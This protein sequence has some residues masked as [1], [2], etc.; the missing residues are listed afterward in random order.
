MSRSGP[1]YQSQGTT[2]CATL[3]HAA[4]NVPHGVGNDAGLVV[5][6]DFDLEAIDQYLPG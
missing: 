6:D 3:R 5:G 2:N 1:G 4:P